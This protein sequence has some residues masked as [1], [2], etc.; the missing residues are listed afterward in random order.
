MFVQGWPMAHTKYRLSYAL[1]LHSNDQ[2]MGPLEYFG[3]SLAKA[4][5]EVYYLNQHFEEKS[6]TKM[7]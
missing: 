4:K 6:F 7:L 3:Q 2:A 1:E 5:H